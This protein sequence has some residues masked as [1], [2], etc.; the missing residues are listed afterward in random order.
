MKRYRTKFKESYD[1]VSYDQVFNDIINNEAS[2]VT[3]YTDEP[4]RMDIKNVKIKPLYGKSLSL[5]SGTFI[6]ETGGEKDILK[7]EIDYFPNKKIY[8]ITYKTKNVLK[9]QL[10]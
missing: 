5:T 1:Q 7:C 9:L 4:S 3:F 10:I 6:F 8:I 2:W